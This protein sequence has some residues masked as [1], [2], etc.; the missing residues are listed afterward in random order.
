MIV[1]T[2]DKRTIVPVFK[3]NLSIL[4]NPENLFALF[5]LS[6][7]KLYYGVFFI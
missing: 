6:S 2:S 7:R 5:G 4:H 1:F 3:Q